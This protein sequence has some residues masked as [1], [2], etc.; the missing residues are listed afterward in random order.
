M[1]SARWTPLTR[2]DG[3]GYQHEESGVFGDRIEIP[4]PRQTLTLGSSQ[5]MR[6]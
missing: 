3:G 4:V 5:F 1:L 6:I 2:P